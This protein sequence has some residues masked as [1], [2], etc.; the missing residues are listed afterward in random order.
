VSVPSPAAATLDDRDRQ[1]PS[2][3]V[4]AQG[5]GWR[6]ADVV[7]TAGPRDR[8]FEEQHGW[9]SVAVV[10][11]GSFQYRSPAGNA[12]MVPGA[13]LLGNAGDHFTCR[14]DHGTGDRC[15]VFWYAPSRLERLLHEA[16]SRRGRFRS[17][18][19]PPLRAVA[20]L[21]AD[22]AALLA[23]P[24]PSRAV[25]EAISVRAAAVAAGGDA[26]ACHATRDLDAG[27]LARV[28]RVVRMLDH[29]A[30]APAGVRPLARIARLSPYQF[31]RCFDALTGT[32]PHQYVLRT[33]L[34]RAAARLRQDAANV[35]EIALA[36]GFGDVSNFTRTFKRE[37]GLT[38]RAYRVAG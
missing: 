35:A 32:T 33:R 25:A 17:A 5:D 14:H 21:A 7:C 13:L 26:G 6:I 8:P 30:D 19:I 18:R 16:G 15:V 20:P 29:D 31:I 4:L 24:S 1:L 2:Y 23:S 11:S 10:L 36:S 34:R 12:L 27:A 37:F 38:P 3:R 28:T 22:A 9:S